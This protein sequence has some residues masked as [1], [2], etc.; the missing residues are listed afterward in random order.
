MEC[1]ILFSGENKTHISRL[2]VFQ[3]IG[4]LKHIGYSDTSTNYAY[5]LQHLQFKKGL[6][7]YLQS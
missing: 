2:S 4:F 6:S 1:Q 5:I 7:K 3:K